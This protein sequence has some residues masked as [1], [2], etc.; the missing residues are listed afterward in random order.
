MSSDDEA[1]EWEREQ[2]LRGTQSRR[3]INP[4]QRDENKD[5]IDVASAKKYV[6]SNIERVQNNIESIK[7]SMGGL[8]L[9]I[10][11]Y[12]KRIDDLKKHIQKVESSEA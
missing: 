4:H 6:C 5:I 3:P 2:M 7:R 12:E 8:R 10:V 9:E 11:R 1:D